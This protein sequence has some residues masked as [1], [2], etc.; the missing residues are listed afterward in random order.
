MG[1]DC[2]GL[3]RA[4]ASCMHARTLWK[5]PKINSACTPINL[6]RFLDQAPQTAI[7]AIAVTNRNCSLAFN[8]TLKLSLAGVHG[9]SRVCGPPRGHQVHAIHAQKAQV[10]HQVASTAN[11]LQQTANP[12]FQVVAK[13]PNSIVAFKMPNNK[14]RNRSH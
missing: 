2:N 5:E 12:P 1:D 8:W 9:Q 6:L 10:V 13:S 4:M 14:T 3:H 11:C 7:T